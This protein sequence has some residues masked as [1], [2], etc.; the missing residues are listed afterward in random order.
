MLSEK[1]NTDWRLNSFIV[2]Y[3]K[4]YKHEQTIDR[5]EGT[6]EFMNKDSEKFSFKIKQDMAQRYLNLIAPEIVEQ[7]NELGE[8]LKESLGLS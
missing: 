8:K 1:I 6:I 3:K 2:E 5:Y 7:A 4:G